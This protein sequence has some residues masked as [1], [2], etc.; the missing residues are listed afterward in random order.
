MY[1]EKFYRKYKTYERYII[2][3]YTSP[4]HFFIYDNLINQQEFKHT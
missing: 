1:K 4:N 2:L 3:D